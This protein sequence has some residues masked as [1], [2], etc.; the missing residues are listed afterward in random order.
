MTPHTKSALIET[1]PLVAAIL[2]S[3]GL[4][5]AAAA[6]Q[7]PLIPRPSSLVANP[8]PASYSFGL[9]WSESPDAE[10]T[11]YRVY[12]SNTKT[13]ALWRM[14]QQIARTNTVRVTVTNLPVWFVCRAVDAAGNESRDSN[15]AGVLGR[16]QVLTVW[17]EISS[18]TTTWKPLAAVACQ[19]NPVGAAF[20]RVAA[21]LTNRW[22]TE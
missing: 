11:G 2:I 10:V 15:M 12:I 4:L 18:N 8:K 20:F 6:I 3:F 1:A 21:S 14:L 9:A 22:R 7:P 13:N 19:T 16:D 17:S 5:I